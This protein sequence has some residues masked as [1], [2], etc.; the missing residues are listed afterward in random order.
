MAEQRVEGDDSCS[1]NG[2]TCACGHGRRNKHG[3]THCDDCRKAWSGFVHA[4]KKSGSVGTNKR[5]ELK[6][7]YEKN[8]QSL[9]KTFEEWKNQHPPGKTTHKR[10]KFNPITRCTFFDE[11]END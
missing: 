5:S 10:P 7:R 6:M 9:Q 11:D 4:V 8:N 1:A 2:E 3:Y